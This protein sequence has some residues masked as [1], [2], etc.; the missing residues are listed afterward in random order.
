[1]QVRDIQN[2]SIDDMVFEYRNRSYGAYLLRQIYNKNVAISTMVATGLFLLFIAT[3]YILA[4]SKGP[5]VEKKLDLSEVDLQQA[6]PQDPKEPPPPVV[7]PPPPLK[8]TIQF[9]PPEPVEDVKVKE[10]RVVTQDELKDL[11]ISNKTE[12]GD[13]NGVDRSL[14]DDNNKGPVEV[15]DNTVQTYVEQMPEFP[16][17]EAALN[18][19]LAKN[20]NYPPMAVE[21]EI[22]GKV[23]VSFVVGKDGKIRDVKVEKGIGFGCDEEAK[24]V[25]GNMPAWN[26]GKQNGRAVNVSYRVPVKFILH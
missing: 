6:P 9:T 19:Y 17:G 16:G 11:D 13:P 15:E 20:I 21:N 7:E 4:L 10:N 26:P 3:P 14:L 25:V 12:I 1:M 18:A 2:A 5:K 8:S 22:Q 24:R 23:T